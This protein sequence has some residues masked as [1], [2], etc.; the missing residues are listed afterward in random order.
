MT[1]L[2]LGLMASDSTLILHAG[3]ER[4]INQ[5]AFSFLRSPS[6]TCNAHFTSLSASSTTQISLHF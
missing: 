1:T 5:A 6:S 2:I 4:F 3:G